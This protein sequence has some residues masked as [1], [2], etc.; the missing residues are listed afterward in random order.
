MSI[1]TI[2]EVIS[3]EESGILLVP[4]NPASLAGRRE[5]LPRLKPL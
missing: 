2:V 5:N 1:H 3:I 4:V